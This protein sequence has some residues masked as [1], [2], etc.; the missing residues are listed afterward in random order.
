MATVLLLA[1]LFGSVIAIILMIYL[2]DR[3]KRLEAVSVQASSVMVQASAAAPVPDN[4]FLGLSGKALW[5]AMS[6]KLPEGFKQEDLTP[7]KGRFEF[8]LQNHIGLLFDLGKKDSVAGKSQET[9]NNPLEIK[10]LR[11]SLASWIPAQHVANIYKAGYES[12]EADEVGIQRLKADIDDAAGIL[13]SRTD[14]TIKQ[15]FSEKLFSAAAAALPSADK[16]IGLDDSSDGAEDSDRAEDSDGADGSD[17]AEGSAK[18]EGSE[19]QI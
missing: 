8:T 9:P 3:I 12:V 6:G 19:E 18:A 16:L 13:F 17:K 14:M 11:G 15:P 5:D 1:V 4:G 7:L 2:I 10:T